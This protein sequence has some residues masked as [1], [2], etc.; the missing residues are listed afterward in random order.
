MRLDHLLSKEKENFKELTVFRSSRGSS[1]E[2]L[3]VE[4]VLLFSHQGMMAET[5]GA[6]ALMGDTRS[7]PEHDG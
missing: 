6:D 5:S 7:H 4:V 2:F 3:Q 1:K